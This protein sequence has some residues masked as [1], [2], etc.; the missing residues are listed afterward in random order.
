MP[1]QQ[2]WFAGGVFRTMRFLWLV[3][4]IF[5]FLQA[6]AWMDAPP[7]RPDH[8][9]TGLWSVDL[10]SIQRRDTLR[11]ITR[12]T[13]TTYFLYRGGEM[14]FEYELVRELAHHLDVEVQ[15]V[16]PPSWDDMIPWLLEGKGDIVAPGFLTTPPGAAQ[17]V[18]TR[19]YD[20][21]YLVV[22]TRVGEDSIRSLEDLAGRTV[23]VRANSPAHTLLTGLNTGLS[24]R[25]RVVALPGTWD[26]EAILAALAD[27]H[28]ST[29][30]APWPAAQNEQSYHPELVIGPALGSPDS[31]AWYV[32]QNAPALLAAVNGYLGDIRR[33][34]FYNILKQKYFE[35]TNRFTRYK[36][37]H[38]DFVR[39]G[40]ISQ[41]DGIIQRSAQ[42]TG[43][44][45]LLVAS[46]I[47]QESS[48]N[49]RAQSWAGAMGLM[50]LMPRTAQV[51]A[52]S[53]PWHPAQNV[54]AGVRHLAT[55]VAR[56]DTL[57]ARTA[58]SFGL[59]SYN[60]G[61]GHLQDA[62]QLAIE[63]GLDPDTWT[64]NVELAF[65]LLSHERYHSR[66]TYGYV[67]GSETI[68]YVNEILRRWDVYQSLL[69]RQ[70][71]PPIL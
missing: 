22:V 62:R 68:T 13:A 42:R 18:R 15:M 54:D 24:G 2:R 1:C 71:R 44:D 66:T 36:K 21:S 30:V 59:A 19:P 23:H 63:E 9:R 67:R 27:G 34:A 64:G 45:W 55:Q 26:T 7:V 57:D 61:Y 53:N 28:I 56:F 46:V 3:I 49:P 38:V 17:A 39:F 35:H 32:R 29:T 69:K 65:D 52:V 47:H 11:V 31:V 51:F 6:S 58:I 60:A 37:A 16:I 20:A 33:S 10:D 14:G 25:I 12:N 50:Q 48:F 5:S 41:Y 70:T 43:L 4:I 8:E 40:R